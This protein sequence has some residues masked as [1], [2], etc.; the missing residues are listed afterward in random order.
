MS[1]ENFGVRDGE[2]DR[3]TGDKIAGATGPDVKLGG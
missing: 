3:S 1:R 2:A